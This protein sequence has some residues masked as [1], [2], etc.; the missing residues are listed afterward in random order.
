[1]TFA[2]RRLSILTALCTVGPVAPAAP[3]PNPLQVALVCETRSIQPG[4][5]FLAGLLL[6]HPESYHSYWR[7]P[8]IVGVPTRLKW[9]LPKGWKAGPIQWPTPERVFMFKIKAQGFHGQKLL[10][11]EITPPANLQ[12]G[13]QIRLTATASWMCCGRDCNPGFEKLELQIPTAAAPP[14]P[15][16]THARDFSAA[17]A[18]LPAALPG[19]KVHASKTG[20]RITIQAA[21]I[22]QETRKHFKNIHSATFF[23]EDGL[24]DP[25]RAEAFLRKPDRIFL[26]LAVSEFAP[27][28]VPGELRGILVT[29]SGW[30]PGQPGRGLLVRVPLD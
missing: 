8:G 2:A 20:N 25:N 16:P 26:E 29:P 18:S 14:D 28:P 9:D 24:T 3:P 7:F 11:V 15:N 27:Q 19:W 17:K 12:T 22:S 30:L 21:P 10:P 1:M 4:K 23:T 6:Q 13:S 5:P